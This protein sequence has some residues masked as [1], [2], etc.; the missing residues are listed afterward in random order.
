[1]EAR[2]RSGMAA[3]KIWNIVRAML[4]MLR[5]GIA[6]S[7]ITV[8]LNLMYKRGKL[9]FVKNL[10]MFH[11]FTCRSHD[12]TQY[13]SPSCEYEFSCTNTPAL[14]KRNHHRFF[15]SSSS[16]YDHVPPFNPVHKLLLD[17]LNNNTTTTINSPSPSPLVPL[18]GFGES[19]IGRQL[20]VTDSP[21][22]LNDDG[23]SHVDAAAQEF[24]NKFYK[25]LNS[26]NKMPPFHSPFHNCCHRS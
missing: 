15:K 22:P 11:Q 6:K 4:L 21:F 2:S 1:M 17:M 19:P 25:H 10:L 7:K 24:I 9:A 12:H 16:Q 3:K 20:R 26:Q 18:P 13:L 8:E 5:K 14:I 23:D